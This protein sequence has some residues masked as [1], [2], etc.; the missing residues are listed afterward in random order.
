MTKI[1]ISY[2][3][4]GLDKFLWSVTQAAVGDT[5]T[6]LMTFVGLVGQSH[7]KLAYSPAFCTTLC[8]LIGCLQPCTAEAL[9][10]TRLINH[11]LFFKASATK[12]RFPLTVFHLM[13]LIW[14]NWL[15][16]CIFASSEL[17]CPRLANFQLPTDMTLGWEMILI[18]VN[19]CMRILVAN[20]QLNQIIFCTL[21]FMKH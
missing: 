17:L 7:L 20:Q 19:V 3:R 4:L 11:P 9:D 6:Y 16:T 10:L 18:S 12:L 5:T 8:K 14:K 1:C 21:L 15:H 2:I 13:I